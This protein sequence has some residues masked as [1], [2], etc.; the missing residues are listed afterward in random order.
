[1]SVGSALFSDAQ[2]KLYP[3]IFG[4]PQ[5]DFHVS[6]LRR[7]TGLG[8]ASLQ[9]E[10]KRLSE[11]GLIRARWMGNQRRLQ[12]NPEAPV[13]ADLV[14]LVTK[15]IGVAEPL[16]QALAPFRDRVALAFVFGSVAKRVEDASSDIDVL[17]VSDQLTHFEL[18]E[19]LLP[20]EAQL[21]RSIELSLYGV[22]EWAGRVMEG[23]PFVTRILAQ[24]K[25]WLMPEEGGD[26]SRQSMRAQSSSD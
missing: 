17:V 12:A 4:Q 8:S 2:A 5:R 16:K 7:L 24:D 22:S 14:A 21:G 3:W 1:M 11:A 9:R 20:V 15:T 10:L 18:R 6:E 26:E 19:V 23:Q 13:F 25:I